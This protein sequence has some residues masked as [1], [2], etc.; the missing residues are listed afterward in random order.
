MTHLA[1]KPAQ[2]SGEFLIGGDLPVVRLGYGTMQLPG[3]GVWG[4]P[5]DLDEVIRVLRR[6]C[7]SCYAPRRPM[8]PA[9]A[10]RCCGCRRPEAVL[11]NCS[12]R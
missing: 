4:E 10:R 12:D 6:N 5:R 2:A 7:A 3:P 8:R 1:S 11:P 9:A